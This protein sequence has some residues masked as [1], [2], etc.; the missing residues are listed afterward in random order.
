MPSAQAPP[1]PCEHGGGAKADLVAGVAVQRGRLHAA[2]LNSRHRR[3]RLCLLESGVPHGGGANLAG[4]PVDPGQVGRQLE[5][6]GGRVAGRS[7]GQGDVVV[8]APTGRHV[9]H[10]EALRTLMILE[11]DRPAAGFDRRRLVEVPSAGCQGA[12]RYVVVD[13][14]GL[15]CAGRPVHADQGQDQG[16]GRG[17]PGGVP[18]PAQGPA[19]P[20]APEHRLEL[21]LE[22][23]REVRCRDGEPRPQILVTQHRRSPPRAGQRPGGRVLGTGA[24]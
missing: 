17:Q 5:A 10:E 22:V 15:R 2:C 19:R 12:H 14:V 16:N 8:L 11:L 9:H 3:Q 1:R 24:A 21:G 20:R 18:A 7:T 4:A 6:T 23:R 13:G